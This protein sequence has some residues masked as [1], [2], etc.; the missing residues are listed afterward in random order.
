[1]TENTS[2]LQFSKFIACKSFG[3]SG[4]TFKMDEYDKKIEALWESIH[5]EVFTKLE[6]SI[7][8]KV[9]YHLQERHIPGYNGIKVT[10]YATLDYY[11]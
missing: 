11:P 6:D 3:H 5:T 10:I 2:A 9:S 8:K 1:M 4:E 7:A